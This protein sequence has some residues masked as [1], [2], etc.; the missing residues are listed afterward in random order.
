M[1]TRPSKIPGGST[2]SVK[3]ASLSIVFYPP[4]YAGMMKIFPLS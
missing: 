1:P 3:R 4:F 2:S